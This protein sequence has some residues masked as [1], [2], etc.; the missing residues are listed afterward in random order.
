[1]SERDHFEILI[2]FLEDIHLFSYFPREQVSV[3]KTRGLPVGVVDV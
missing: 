1:M 3:G 2:T